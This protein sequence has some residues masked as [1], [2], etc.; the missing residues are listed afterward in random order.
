MRTEVT[1]VCLLH[2]KQGAESKYYFFGNALWKVYNHFN[3]L[4]L[5]S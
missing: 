4:L 5:S 1:A 2:S 3:V